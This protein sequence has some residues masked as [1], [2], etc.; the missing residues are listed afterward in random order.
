MLNNHKPFFTVEDASRVALE[1]YS[2]LV[3][4]HT[5]P[6][7]RDY[8]FHLKIETG[9]EFVLKIAPAEEQRDVIDLQNKA[10]EHLAAHDPA[11]LLPHV[12]VTTEGKSIATFTNTGGTTHFV[13][14]L[15]YI[16]GK[17]LAETRLHTP[18]LL[19]SL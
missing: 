5:L 9:Q 7:E 12:R 15:S 2:L 4:A 11:L 14:I 17:V 6:G 18:E 10:L 13:R 8:N 19:N 3:E 1:Q 16:P